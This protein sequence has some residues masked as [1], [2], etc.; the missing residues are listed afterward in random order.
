MEAAGLRTEAE[1]DG[2]GGYGWNEAIAEFEQDPKY[3]WRNPGF[4]QTDDHPV[5]NVSWND[6]IAFCNKLSEQEGLK[7]YYP[8]G[9]GSPSGGDGYRLPTEAEWEYACRAGTTTRYE[10]GDDPETLATVGNIADGTAKA[11]YS[12]LDLCD[13]GAGRFRLYSARGPIPAEHLR[14]PRHARECL[15]VVLGRL[16]SRLLQGFASGRSAG[17]FGGRGPGDP[18]RELVHHPAVLPVGGPRRVHA[19]LPDRQPRLSAGPS[20]VWAVEAGQAEP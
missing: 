18:G 17:G 14:P 16:P 7:P 4:P 6:A 1:T 19:G 8:P 20:P 5:V 2:K 15:G 11:K 3:T 13:H 9:G 12:D 10:S